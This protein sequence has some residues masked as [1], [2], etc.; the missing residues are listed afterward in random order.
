MDKFILDEIKDLS[1]Q[2]SIVALYRIVEL[3]TKSIIRHVY[4]DT[5]ISDSLFDIRKLRS[6][7]KNDFNVELDKEK[8]QYPFH[9]IIWA[10]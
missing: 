4:E 6:K 10:G 5:A 1:E 7:I 9:A 8:S 3:K 2:L